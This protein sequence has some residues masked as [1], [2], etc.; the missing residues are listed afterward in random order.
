M[1]FKE[2]YT[3]ISNPNVFFFR[4]RLVSTNLLVRENTPIRKFCAM[5]R[6]LTCFAIY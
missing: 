2:L 6:H 4:N 1:Y 3:Y 5:Q